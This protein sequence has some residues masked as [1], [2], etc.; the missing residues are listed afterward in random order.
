MNQ[1]NTPEQPAGP[2]DF[3]AEP[4]QVIIGLR[5]DSEGER[6]ITGMAVTPEAVMP[7]DNRPD[8]RIPAVYFAQWLDRNMEQLQH[9][10]GVEYTQYMNLR[11]LTEKPGHPPSLAL[12][13]P[14]GQR[15]GT[16]RT[17]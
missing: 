16:D 2:R 5:S 11:R 17:Q 4:W 3:N 12:V 14:S 1:D 10:A 9:M 13:D 15:L 8:K 6:V 7:P